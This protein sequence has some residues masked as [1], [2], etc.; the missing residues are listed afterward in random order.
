M[1][2]FR[3]KVCGVTEPEIVVDLACAGVDAIGL[4]FAPLSRRR[5]TQ[6]TA[7]EIASA[8][9]AGL[10]K[11]GV[12]VDASIGEMIDCCESVPLDLV[13]LH[14]SESWQIYD[15]L[16]GLL[17][18][19]KIVRALPWT[20][21]AGQTINAFLDQAAAVDRLPAAI[22]VDSAVAGRFG[23]TGAVVAWNEVGAWLRHYPQVPLILAGGL[24][25][26]NVADAVR[27]ARPDGV[28]VAGG[29]EISPSHKD[30]NACRLFAAEAVA[31][32]IRT[33]SADR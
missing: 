8:C 27:E 26:E 10:L 17:G 12:F 20:D 7:R 23:G 2:P 3:I 21:S 9:P 25:P 4:N 6:E 33:P 24:R 29:V 1:V 19:G 32:G 13:Q 14:G 30:L 5:V 16:F 18:P 22:L 31:A 15:E 28:D 11:I